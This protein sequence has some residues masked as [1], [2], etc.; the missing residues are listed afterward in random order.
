LKQFLKQPL[1]KPLLISYLGIPQSL[2]SFGIPRIAG[3]I[4]RQNPGAVTLFR[5]ARGA[6]RAAHFAVL[7]K[8]LH[9]RS[10]VFITFL[11]Y[12]TRGVFHPRSLRITTAQ[13]FFD[14]VRPYFGAFLVYETE[15]ES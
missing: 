4:Q 12:E 8:N 7:K 15:G 14:P 6:D 10:S 13:H 1:L 5:A 2:R 9:R 3:A 11:V